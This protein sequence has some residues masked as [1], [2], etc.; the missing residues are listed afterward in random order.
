MEILL[1]IYTLQSRRIVVERLH[2]PCRA[3]FFVPEIVIFHPST[4][5]QIESEKIKIT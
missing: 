4:Q 5:H 1:R 3:P 2:A